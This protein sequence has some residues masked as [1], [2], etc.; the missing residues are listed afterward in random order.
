MGRPER[1]ALSLRFK[2]KNGQ[3]FLCILPD[4]WENAAAV[5]DKNCELLYI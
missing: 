3:E 5:L 1:P 4:F 2:H